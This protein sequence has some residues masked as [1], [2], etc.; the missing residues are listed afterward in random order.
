M[1]V[2]SAII[3]VLV[4]YLLGSIN[5]SLIVGRFYNFDVREHGSK[6]AGLTNTYRTIG[7]I[8]ALWVIVGDV[9][10]SVIS[11]LVGYYLLKDFILL[12]VMLGGTAAVIGHNWPIYFGFRGGKGILATFTVILL[13]NWKIALILLAIFI[14]VVL[15][16]KYVSLGSIAASIMLPI[17]GLV[18]NQGWAFVIFALILG[19]IAIIRHIPNVERIINKTESTI[20][21]RT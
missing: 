19:S 1:V 10:K 13:A 12:G 20:Y 18:L 15:F 21:N 8:A 17:M 2:F 14:I 6:N 7:K 9:L 11:C 3:T 5:T 4:G 16:T